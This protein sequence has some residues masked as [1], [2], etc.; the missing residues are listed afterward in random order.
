MKFLTATV[1][2]ACFCA[3]LAQAAPSPEVIKI[4]VQMLFPSVRVNDGCSGTIVHSSRA[5]KSGEVTTLVLTARHCMKDMESVTNK[6]VVPI[7][8]AT[9]QLVEER[10]LFADFKAK[11]SKSDTAV[12]VLK[13][14]ATL[15]ET[16]ALVAK[17]DTALYAAED[18]WAVGFP[19]GASI[20][21]TRGFLGPLERSDFGDGEREFY[22]ASPGVA[23]GSSG[24]GLFHISEDGKYEMIGLSTGV[25]NAGSFMG[26]FTPIKPIADFLAKQLPQGR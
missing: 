1:L 3:S 22:R 10:T 9:L 18:V 7:Y 2:A 6:V 15:Y 11:D 5:Q 19:Q 14:K 20:T 12:L 8:S 21:L 4:N 17:P 26:I 23:P 25:Y 13:D 24:G 16:V